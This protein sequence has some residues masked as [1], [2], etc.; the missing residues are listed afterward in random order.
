MENYIVKMDGMKVRTF[1][2]FLLAYTF[3]KKHCKGKIEI[4]ALSERELPKASSKPHNYF[5]NNY[6]AYKYNPMAAME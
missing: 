1:D 5:F 6:G 4:V 3:A 2:N